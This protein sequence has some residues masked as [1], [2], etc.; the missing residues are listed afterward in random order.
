VSLVGTTLIASAPPV[1]AAA[2]P[3]D[4]ANALV[5][6]GI[7]VT[8]ASFVTLASPAAVEVRTD[9]VAGF[10]IDAGGSYAA[11]STGDTALLIQPNSGGSQGQDLGAP[12]YRTTFD[13]TTLKID[14]EVQS[15]FN[16]LTSLK[17]RFLSEEFPEFVL[18]GF[19]DAAIV[20][21]DGNDWSIVNQKVVAPHNIAFVG[22][23]PLSVDTSGPTQAQAS[24]A[25]GTAFDGATPILSARSPINA[26]PHSLY[27]T[28]FDQGDAIYDSM[29]LVDDLR[30]SAVADPAAECPVGAFA[31]NVNPPNRFVPVFPDRIVDTRT[32]LGLPGPLAATTST[33][34]QVTGRGGIPANGVAA[35]VLNMTVTQPSGSGFVR[36]TPAGGTSFVS[37]LN[38]ESAGQD[39][40][41]LVTVPV[42][43]DGRVDVF[44]QS[45]THLVVDVFGYYTAAAAATSGRLIAVDPTRLLDTRSAIGVPGTTPVPSGGRIDVQVTG[46]GPVPATGVSALVRNVTATQAAGGGFVTVW[47][48]GQPQP[49]TSNLNLVRA[50]QTIPNQ[51]IVPVG[52]SGQISLFTLQSAHLLVDVAGYFTDSTAPLSSTGLFIPITPARLLDTREANG[53]PSSL[54]PAAGETV[55]PDITGRGGVPLVGASAIVGNTTA[56]ESAADGYVTVFP[57]SIA[58]PTASNLNLERAGQT[59]ANHTTV[60]LNDGGVSVFTQRGTHLILDVSGFYTG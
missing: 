1:S 30:A 27:I 10:P 44:S 33:S 60:K 49:P 52:A 39:L 15:G 28:I 58:M 57:R 59:I 56:T 2:A 54:R 16:C 51:V 55:S 46:R 32:G 47:P 17:L 9:A 18:E 42:S 5:G 8:G 36:V 31:T 40:A 20:E 11:F 6:S 37:N 53:V 25:T 24:E 14:F 29:V 21:L 3:L 26:G 50:D 35:V 34:I 12:A 22:T 38:V 7:S 23:E 13:A 48:A 45:A 41:N 19:N 4:L 43:A